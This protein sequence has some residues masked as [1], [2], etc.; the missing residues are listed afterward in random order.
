[1]PLNK[2]KAGF[3]LV[4]LLVVI[5]IIG[6]LIALLLPAVQQAREA[7]R[8]M[9]CSNNFKQL[10][11][12]FHNYHDTF[13]TFPPYVIKSSHPDNYSHWESYSGFTFILPFI[14][15]ANLHERIKT[16]SQDFFLKNDAGAVH[17][18]HRRNPISAF[19]CPSDGNFPDSAF[20]GNSNYAMSSGPNLS[21]NVDPSREN[22]AFRRVEGTRFSDITDGTSNTIMLGEFLIGD[23]DS[24]GYKLKQDVIR[25]KSWS[26]GFE[27]TTQGVITQ[28]TVDAYGTTC[29]SDPSSQ[30]VAAGREW[31]RGVP[32]HTVFNTLAPPNWKYPACMSCGVCGAGDSKGVFPARSRHPGGAMHA[33]ADGSVSFISETTDYQSYHAMGSR[34]GGEVIASP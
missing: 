33:L 1:M 9:Q 23:N 14:E 20:L 16:A 3:T 10:G 30:S 4:E 18:L 12:A 24:T 22:G 28:A 29:N 2:P 5:A 31:I 8:R 6:V 34:N 17:P 27:S 13:K 11:L 26:G 32:Y 15:Q 21:W 19:K 7:A 25:G